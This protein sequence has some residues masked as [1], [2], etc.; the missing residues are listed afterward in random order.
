MPQSPL[1]ILGAGSV[2]N[3]YKELRA[4]NCCQIRQDSPHG[5]NYPPKLVMINSKR[6]MSCRS[7]QGSNLENAWELANSP[8]GDLFKDSAEKALQVKIETLSLGFCPDCKL[9][10]LLEVTDIKMTYDDYL[11]RSNITNALNSYYEQTA[12]RLISEYNLIPG[13]TIVDI[14]SNDGTFLVNFHEKGFLVIGVEPTLANAE[15]AAHKGV[16]T[17]NMYFDRKSVELILESGSCPSLIS[18]NYTLANIPELHSFVGNIEKLM[19]ENTILSVITGYHPD[20]YAV[21]MFEY[22]N[23]D[24]LTY[25]TV[26]SMG[27]LCDVL[28]LKIID[29]IRSEHKGGSIQFVISKK[30]SPFKVQS[31]VY[32]LLQ[33]E[34]WLNCNSTQF[35]KELALRVQEIS[36]KVGKI[37]ASS[38]YSDVFGIGASISTTYLCN[39]FHLNDRIKKLF[40]DDT[41]KIGRFAPAT[42]IFVDS[43]SKIPNDINAIAIILAWQHSEKLLNRLREV[44]FPGK[45]LIPLPVPRLINQ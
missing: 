5:K 29:V 40:D 35:T 45:I 7:C 27:N 37:L 28:D 21:N 22:I 16:H 41:N 38:Q 14:G 10:Q 42:G 20:Q 13:S 8:Y 15:V 1:K 23:H 30:T 3:F 34:I 17:L 36:V 33:R 25:L 32:Q 9:L 18:I 2:L 26:Q 43:L 31:S 12:S 19:N 4:T 44:G 39:Q 24:H 6:I 11:Y